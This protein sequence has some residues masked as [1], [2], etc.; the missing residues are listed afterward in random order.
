MRQVAGALILLL[1]LVGKASASEQ[2]EAL[3]SRGLVESQRGDQASAM[4]LFDRA[5]AADPRDALAHY[6]RG[7]ALS[8]QGKAAQAIA[9][10]ETSLSLRPDLD[11]AALE[12]GIALVEVGRADDARPWLEQARAQPSLLGQAEFFLGIAALRAEQYDTARASF[13]RAR[14]A[15][16]AL[17]ASTRYYLGVIDYR[18]G[19]RDAAREHFRS[20]LEQS[21]NSAVG[22]EASAFLEVLRQAQGS[23][24]YVYGALSLQYDSNVVLAPADGLP[25]PA[26]SGKSDGRATINAGGVYEMWRDERTQ[27]SVGYDFYQDLQFELTEFNVQNHRPSLLVSTDFGILRGAFLAQYDFFLLDNS[28]W[29]QS[30]TAMPM[31]ILPQGDV[32][33]IE[34][35]LRFQWRDYLRSSFD[36]LNGYNYAGGIRQVLTLGKGGPV[37]WGSFE[38]DN[39]DSDATG[40]ELY[41]YEGLQGEVSLRWPLPWRTTAQAGYRY[42]YE[43]YNDASAVFVPVDNTR[44]D[45]EHRTGV[46]LRKDLNEMISL[47]A[48]WVGTWNLS[49]KQDFEYD[50][51]ITSLGVELRY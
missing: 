24:S 32:G 36:I 49:N 21:P 38:V 6:H 17:L 45:R 25:D 27:V 1:A 12:L 29:L 15:D 31:V 4:D 11:E 35:Y 5:V 19:N 40:G 20:V 48:A 39:Q 2:S 37:L 42:R 33:R 28:G 41:E 51:H 30:V 26:I 3:F 47:V 18:T 8:R 34:T 43:D 10:F 23:G 50:R 7:V 46:T 13:E 14:A 16:P 44:V 22:R 9:D